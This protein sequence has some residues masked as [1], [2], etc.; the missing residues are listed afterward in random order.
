[1]DKIEKQ[2]FIAKRA[3]KE[4]QNNTIVNLGIGIPTKIPD[5]LPEGVN[6]L[7]HS[8]NGFVGLGPS[9]TE[10]NL[11]KTIINAGGIHSTIKAGG[12]FFDSSVSFGMIRGGHIDLTVLGSLQV[13]AKGNIANYLIPGKKVPGMGGAM[14][15]LSGG[16]KRV[17]VTMEHTAGE[18]PKILEECTLPFTGVGV[19]NLIIT[20]MGVFRVTPEGIVLEEINSIYTVEE[21]QNATGAKLIIS[22]NLIKI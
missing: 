2:N 9:P 1:M 16:V 18:T 6:V 21:V 8:E 5:F 14:D 19:V 10:E 4:L 7:L 3:A 13:D 20:E 12:Y 15:L 17:I 11:D 22:E